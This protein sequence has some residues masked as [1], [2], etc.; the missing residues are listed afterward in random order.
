VA[1]GAL[2]AVGRPLRDPA[3]VGIIAGYLLARY[4][5]DLGLS[6]SRTVATGIVVVC[7]LAVVMRLETEPGRRRLAVAGLC[8]LMALLFALALIVPFLRNFYELS[9]PAGEAVAAWALGTALGVG[10][11]LVALRLLRV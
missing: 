5:F 3:G 1:T 2:P 7:G 6:R 9:T 4:G 11:M 10:T 8:A